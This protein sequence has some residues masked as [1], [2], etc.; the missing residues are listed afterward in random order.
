MVIRTTWRS[1]GPG[2]GSGRAAQACR[3]DAN[4]CA[5]SVG[6][7]AVTAPAGSLSSEPGL[8]CSDVGGSDVVG[9]AASEL[10]VPDNRVVTAKGVG[11]FTMGDGSPSVLLFRV[12][13]ADG[14]EKCSAVQALT[15][16]WS[17]SAKAALFCW[18]MR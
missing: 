7:N 5:A 16:S 12:V 9:V 4:I 18:Q 3:E 6:L 17:T 15:A 11:P 10:E 8:L 2:L 14:G 1:L 13:E